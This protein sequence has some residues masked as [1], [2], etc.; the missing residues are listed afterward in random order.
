MLRTTA[1]VVLCLSLLSSASGEQHGAVDQASQLAHGGTPRAA[2]PLSFEPNQGQ[3]DPS[4][5]SVAHGGG[6]ALSLTAT[7]LQVGSRQSEG[8]PG[9]ASSTGTHSGL[10]VLAI[11]LDGANARAESMAERPLDG[12]V[13]YFPGE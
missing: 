11:D 4:V 13:N 12:R 10:A 3:A 9:R 6:Y 8:H 1:T 5:D 7:R 2:P